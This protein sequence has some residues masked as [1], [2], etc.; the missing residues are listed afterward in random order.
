VVERIMDELHLVPRRGAR[1]GRGAHAG[2]RATGRA[3]LRRGAIA[4][5]STATAPTRSACAPGTGSGLNAAFFTYIGPVHDRAHHEID[6]EILLRDTSA[7]TFNT[8]VDGAPSMAG[9]RR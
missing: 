8:F 2:G 4:S 9:P 3:S 5:P 7:V 6:I 1:V